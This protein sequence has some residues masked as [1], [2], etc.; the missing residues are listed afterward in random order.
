MSMAFVRVPLR[1]D[2]KHLSINAPTTSFRVLH[3]CD[4]QPWPWRKARGHALGGHSRRPEF[5]KGDDG[6]QARFLGDLIRIGSGFPDIIA[7]FSVPAD[8]LGVQA[9]ENVDE[10]LVPLNSSPPNLENS[11]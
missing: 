9:T 7:V 2:E 4:C 6:R 1:A 10:V 3:K 11:N 5:E 8:V